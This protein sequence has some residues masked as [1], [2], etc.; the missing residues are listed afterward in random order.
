MEYVS[1]VGVENNL[2]GKKETESLGQW[3][4]V[5]TLENWSMPCLK[6]FEEFLNR[7]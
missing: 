5:R 6:Q 1:T 7:P 3:M 4:V 2:Y